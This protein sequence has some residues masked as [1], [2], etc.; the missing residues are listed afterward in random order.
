[1]VGSVDHGADPAVPLQG[2]VHQAGRVGGSGQGADGGDPAEFAGDV[3]DDV[4]D[5][6]GGDAVARRGE[7]G[8]RAW[9]T[10]HPHRDRLLVEDVLAALG[11]PVR[12]GIL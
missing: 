6:E 12:L 11:H 5:A 7:F 3:R 1:M 4:A 8:G 10:Y 9:A 2:D